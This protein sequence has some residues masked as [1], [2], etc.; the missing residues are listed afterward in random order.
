MSSDAA[1]FI[2]DIPTEYHRCLGPMI[3]ADYAADMA[4]RVV[5]CCPTRVLE[6]AAGT[7]IATRHLRDLL[8]A[9]ARLTAT[10]LYP[11]M[12]EVA[13]AKF[14]PGERVELQPANA[15]ALPFPDGSFDTVVCQFGVMFFPDQDK[16]YRE[17]RRVLAS[18]GRYLFSVWD[19]HRYN[20]FG[21]LAHETAASFFPADPP[22]F[23]SVPFSCH[24]I[25]PI[26]EALIAAGFRDITVAVVGREKEIPSA[27]TF[28]RGM[29]HGNPLV[30][31][32]RAR[33]SVAPDRVVDALTQA[34]HG[35][36]GADPPSRPSCPRRASRR[37]RTSERL[38]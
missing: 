10:D 7:G 18:G 19:S 9:D 24:R 28:A 12:L 32:I 33:G 14:R 21:R 36:F 13:R 15:T 37:N 23:Y 6:I 2:G 35:E 31:Q 4:Q 11:P 27:A 34:L 16:S 3:F 29:V 26:K 22:P 38:A 30:D 1:G 25:D 17:A 8:P 5:D 20:P